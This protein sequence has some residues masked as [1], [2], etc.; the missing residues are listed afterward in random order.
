MSTTTTTATSS[1]RTTTPV[2]RALQA[3]SGLAVLSLLF[4]FATAGQLFPR[5]GPEELH[6]NGAIALHVLSGSAAVAAVLLW[7][8]GGGPAWVA[9]LAVVDFLLTFVQ[10]ALGGRDSL[11]LHVPGA[12]VLTVGVVWLAAWSFTRPAHG[13]PRAG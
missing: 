3:T 10:A 8:R 12:L 2:R 13:G 1:A 6:A 11:W 9:A 7:R 4:Q 5:G